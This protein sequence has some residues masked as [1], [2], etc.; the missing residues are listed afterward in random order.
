MVSRYPPW[1][2]HPWYGSNPRPV[3]SCSARRL[4]IVNVSSEASSLAGEVKTL[5]ECVGSKHFGR[6]KGLW[7]TRSDWEN[8]S[9][10][11]TLKHPI[12]ASNFWYRVLW[13]IPTVS[14]DGI[15][16]CHFLESW[17]PEIAWNCCICLCFCWLEHFSRMRSKGSRFTLGVWGLRVCSLDVAFTVATVRNRPQPSATVRNRP[18]DPRMAVP[19]GS[20]AEVV[21]FGGF[22]RVVASFRVAGV[23]LRDIQTCCATC[24][25]SF[26][27]AGAILLWRFQKM[28]CSFRGRRSTLDVSI[29]IFRGRRSTLDVSCC[30]FFVNR[31]GRAASS[32]DK[33]QIPWQAWH[34][35]TCAENWRKPRTKHRFWGC[36][37]SG[38][39]ENS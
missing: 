19:M 36:K 7:P 14:C 18:R 4:R 39:K 24:W 2:I 3:G 5:G 31:I 33:V 34:F 28:C 15:L 1:S 20:S 25:Q 8:W 32:G 16:Q 22:R 38:S 9:P 12:Q 26:C 17:A 29:V 10:R 35:V 6:A 27:V 11:S 13:P 23:A 30:V 37:F 21:I